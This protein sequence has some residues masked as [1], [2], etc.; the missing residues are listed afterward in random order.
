MFFWHTHA[1]FLQT[2]LNLLLCILSIFLL[3]WQSLSECLF[4]F[5]VYLVLLSNFI[6]PA[7]LSLLSIHVFLSEAIV[8]IVILVLILVLILILIVTMVLTTWKLC[9]YV[10]RHFHRIRQFEFSLHLWLS[11]AN[12]F[13]L[14][15]AL[16]Q[17]K[18]ISHFIKLLGRLGTNRLF[19]PGLC[20]D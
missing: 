5:D 18:S 6:D 2:F 3:F 20:Q 11:H 13:R 16:G 1:L 8:V 4:G 9:H 7:G 19:N 12:Y 10:T 14:N 15:L 17:S